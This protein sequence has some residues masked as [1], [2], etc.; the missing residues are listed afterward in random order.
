MRRHVIELT[1]AASLAT[2]TASGRSMASPEPAAPARPNVIFILADDLGWAELGSYGQEKIRTPSLDRLAAEGVRFTQAYSGS[3]VC[4][5]S[6][7]VL[8]TGLHPGTRPS[9]TTSRCSP[10]GRGRCPRPR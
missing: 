6:R 7:S 8:M 1:V 4:A 5:P 9:A 3:A 2:F 10:R